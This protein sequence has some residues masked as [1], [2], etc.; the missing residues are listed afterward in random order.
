VAVRLKGGGV[1]MR[2]LTTEKQEPAVAAKGGKVRWTICGAKAI[3][4]DADEVSCPQAD[5]S[6]ED[7]LR[8]IRISW[9]QIVGETA[10]HNPAPIL[11]NR[12]FGGGAIARAV[13]TTAREEGSAGD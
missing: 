2:S 1:K 13:G 5:V 8:T 4:A 10:E 3:G 12:G 11:G 6:Q 7:I 9:R